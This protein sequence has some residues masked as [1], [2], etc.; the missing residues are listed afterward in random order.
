MQHACETSQMR[1]KFGRI[2]GGKI[3][4]ER[5]RCRRDPIQLVLVIKRPGREADH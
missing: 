1:A 4:Y 3:P 5:P 2:S